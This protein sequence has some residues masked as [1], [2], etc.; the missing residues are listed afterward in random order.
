MTDF[1]E[2]AQAEPRALARYVRPRDLAAE[3]RLPTYINRLDLLQAEGPRGLAGALYGRIARLGLNYDLAPF[4]PRSGVVQKIRTSAHILAEGRATCL[5]LAVAFAAACL[6]NDL[7][8]LIVTVEGHA[9]AGFSATRTRQKVGRAPKA[10]A[11]T[12]G[13]LDDGA[14]L[15]ELAGQ[16]FVLVECT[17]MVRSLSLNATLPEGQGRD[18][19]GA[20]SYERACAAGAEQVAGSIPVGAVPVAG[21]RRFLYA[22]DIHDLQVNQGFAPEAEASADTSFG[23]GGREGVSIRSAGDVHVGGDLTGRDRI[24]TTNTTHT[25]DTITV[26]DIS[27]S[28]GIAIGAGASAT[29]TT[30]VGAGD[31]AAAF[32]LIYQSIQ[33]R[34][35]D[36][37]VDKAEIVETVQRIE[38]EAGKGAAAEA[39]KLERWAKNIAGMAPDILE[40]MA[41]AFAGPATAAGTILKKVIERARGG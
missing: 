30:G 41:A 35:I 4:D 22:L 32:A 2:W 23:A 1:Y 13:L 37:G 10:L 24:T 33:A 5:D 19:S 29:V 8:S 3:F 16:E 21:Q 36:P 7:L 40:V 11:W 6:E 9:F 28:S 17:G 14:V 38:K 12:K 39:G 15:Q 18:A 25:G 26:G 31:L 27:G 34:P 20:M